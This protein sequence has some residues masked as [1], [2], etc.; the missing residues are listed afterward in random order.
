MQFN[1]L[2]PEYPKTRENT[3]NSFYKIWI[4]IWFFCWIIPIEIPKIIFDE[5]LIWHGLLCENNTG[6]SCVRRK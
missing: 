2:K 4:Q 1:Q 3:R 6:M 5:N